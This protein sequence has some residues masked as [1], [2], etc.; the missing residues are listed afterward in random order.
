MSSRVSKISPLHLRLSP[1]RYLQVLLLFFYLGSLLLVWYLPLPVWLCLLLTPILLFD[2]RRHWLRYAS[3]SDPRAVCC[4][5]WKG[6]GEWSLWFE[7]GV[8]VS[9]LQL[10][11]SVNHPLLT[12][13]NFSDGCNVLLLPD[14]CDAE[15]L[16][17]LRVLLRLKNY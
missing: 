9:P 7:N 14:S 8:L 13:L 12:V 4:V 5:A 6:E 17:R 10:V 3:V 2:L 11:Q 15:S 1:S 16:R